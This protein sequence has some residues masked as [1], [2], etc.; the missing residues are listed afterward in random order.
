MKALQLRKY[1]KPLKVLEIKDV[2]IPTPRPFEVLI[3]VHCAALNPID[4]KIAQGK[5]KAIVPLKFP[6]G[7]GFDVSGVIEQI[8]SEVSKFKV[9]DKVFCRLP[10]HK[11]GAFAEHVCTNE[12]NMAIMPNTS[13]EEAAALP[14]VGLTVI[15]A[16]YNRTKTGMK[17]LIHAGSGGVGTFAIQYAKKILNLDVTVTTSKKNA[18]F[19]K[20]LGADHVI[21]YDEEN[22]VKKKKKYDVVFDTLGGIHTMNS[23]RVLKR[24]GIVVSI[25]GPPDLNFVWSL[26]TNIIHKI[27]LFPMLAL[28]SLPIYLM[29]LTKS[30]KYYRF[31]TQPDGK[32]LEEINGFIDE[33]LIK[34][35]ID[36]VFSFE[37]FQEAINYIM[38]GRAKGKVVL[39]IIR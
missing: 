27:I 15:Q 11:G 22:Y 38:K 18:S 23:F 2:S 19:V 20:A 32:Q 8:G 29:A 16:L 30:A 4:Y 12:K 14:L 1:G 25:G 28:S 26:H 13:F 31:L 33:G 5:L 35:V 17:I 37:D 6:S 9:G 3:K 21:A 7:T 24:N 10:I 39:K 34:A 36:K